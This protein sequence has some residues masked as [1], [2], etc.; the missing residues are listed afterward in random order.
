M[1]IETSYSESPVCCVL[2]PEKST[3]GIFWRKTWLIYPYATFII[4]ISVV[5]DV[6]MTE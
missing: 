5:D 6:L 3:L 1:F 4:A 2:V